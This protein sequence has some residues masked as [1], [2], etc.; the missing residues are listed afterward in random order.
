MDEVPLSEYAL[1]M[2]LTIRSLEKSDFG[3]YICKSSNALGKTEGTIRL[4]GKV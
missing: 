1:L 2:N 3:G 4:R